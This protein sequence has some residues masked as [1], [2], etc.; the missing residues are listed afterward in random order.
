MGRFNEPK[1][2]DAFEIGNGDVSPG[3]NIM[4]VKWSG[5]VSIAGDLT[6]TSNNSRHTISE[7]LNYIQALE[8]RIAILE[9]S[10]TVTPD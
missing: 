3:K 4:E 7:L 8:E 1:S 6:F 9:Q 5:D 2:E 10:L